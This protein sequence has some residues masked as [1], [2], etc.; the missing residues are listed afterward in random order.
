MIISYLITLSIVLGIGGALYTSQWFLAFLAGLAL[1]LTYL[2]SI[3]EK[4][5]KIILPIEFELLIT[6]FIYASFYL[7]MIRDYYD[8]YWWWDIMMHTTSGVFLGFVG[9]L[10]VYTLNFEKK[11]ELKLSPLFIALFSFIFAMAIGALWEVYEF[12]LDSI[13]G[14]MHQLDSLT[15][16][17]WDLILDAVGALFVSILGYFY[18]KRVKIAIFDQLITK[19]V[20]KNPNLFKYFRGKF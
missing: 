18:V 19:F 12:T 1:F 16:T 14:S 13:F 17:M 11:I 6:L 5:Y 7:G 2:P 4:K 15:D 3:F 10:I 20:R 8:Y 9:F